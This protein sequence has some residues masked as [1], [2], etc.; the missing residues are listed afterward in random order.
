MNSASAFRQTLVVRRK[1]PLVQVGSWGAAGVGM[2]MLIAYVLGLLPAGIIGVQLMF[3]GVAGLLLARRNWKPWSKVEV[4]EASDEGV[5]VGGRLRVP[6]A[7]IADG[8]YQPR[9]AST[10]RPAVR[11]LDRWRGTVFEVEVEDEAQGQTL[12]RAL[13]LD[14]SQ[15]RADFY[16]ASPVMGN[17]NA[18]AGA[19]AAVVSLVAI[20]LFTKAMPHYFTPT[21]VVAALLAFL[22]PSKLSIGIDGLVFRWLFYQRFLPM[23]AIVGAAPDGSTGIVV[24][25]ASGKRVTL[26]ATGKQDRGNYDRQH[27]DAIIA[28]INE[29]MTAHRSLGEQRGNATELLRRGGRGHREW[30]ED[31]R[32]LGSATGYRDG[33]VGNEDLW[34]VLEDP[35]APQDARAGA[36][37]VLRGSLGDEG[38]VRVRAVAE[39]TAHPKLRVALDAALDGQDDAYEEALA[40]IE[41][42]A[43]S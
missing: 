31:L 24:R 2:A 19:T 7:A 35:A 25:M 34:R 6:R 33:V 5:S 17:P 22:I 36:L 37:S 26:Y 1:N 27:R 43:Q 11:L 42:K 21:L 41:H 12:L 40:D 10:E 23:D 39:S 4:V 28:R 3:A 8:Y 20:T 29:A 32:K 9:T 15:R 30:L 16:I 14:A 18:R 38:K 13:E